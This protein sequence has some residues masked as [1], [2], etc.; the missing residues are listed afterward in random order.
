MSDELSVPK[1]AKQV[2]EDAQKQLKDVQQILDAEAAQRKEDARPKAPDYPEGHEPMGD[3]TFDDRP[4][5][6]QVDVTE[7]EKTKYFES[8]LAMTPYH[9]EFDL[10]DGNM[11]VTLRA[12]TAE[13]AEEALL[14]AGGDEV[15]SMVDYEAALTRNN[16]A[17]TLVRIQ[18][19]DKTTEYDHGT[20]EERW[21][22]LKSMPTP[23]FTSLLTLSSRFN[24]KIEK[25]S[26]LSIKPNFWRPVSA[27]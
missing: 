19:K 13:E 21:D 5:L 27:S 18:T 26:L 8:I 23:L 20:L 11:V 12:R 22:R 17:Y 7:E 1:S 14:K 15:Q 6:N 24:Q 3:D 4:D 2:H 25:L 9:E 16:L 10:F